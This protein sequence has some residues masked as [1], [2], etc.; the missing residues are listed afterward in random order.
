MYSHLRDTT[1]AKRGGAWDR[2]AANETL[3]RL[4]ALMTEQQI[5]K[6]RVMALIFAADRGE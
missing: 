5:A 1:L 2:N 3:G 4:E 6:A